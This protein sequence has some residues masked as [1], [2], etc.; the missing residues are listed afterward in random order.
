VNPDTG[1]VFPDFSP[2]HKTDASTE[3]DTFFRPIPVFFHDYTG[4]HSDFFEV[5]VTFVCPQFPGS[6]RVETK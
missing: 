3:N 1:A 2:S 4:N 6:H 5:F